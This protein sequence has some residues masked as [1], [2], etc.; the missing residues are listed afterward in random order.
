MPSGQPYI[1]AQYAANK[2]KMIARRASPY[3][4]L[5]CAAHGFFMGGRLLRFAGPLR[6]KIPIRSTLP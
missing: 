3:H 5:P 4:G 1:V 6:L 2:A